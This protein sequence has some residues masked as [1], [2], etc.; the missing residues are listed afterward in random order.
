MCVYVLIVHGAISCNVIIMCGS[1]YTSLNSNHIYVGMYI[2]T[3]IHTSDA[4]QRFCIKLI[5]K[6]CCCIYQTVHT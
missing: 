4:I 2:A 6:I 5:E 3:Y 1:K